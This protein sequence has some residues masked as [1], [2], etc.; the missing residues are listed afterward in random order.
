MKAAVAAGVSS[1]A[2]AHLTVSEV[3]AEASDQTTIFL[4]TEGKRKKRVPSD[5]YNHLQRAFKVNEKMKNRF[6]G[7]EGIAA[8]GVSAGRFGGDNPYVTVD[9]DRSSKKK[10][11]RRGEVPESHQDVRIETA[12][13]AE[14]AEPLCD[15]DIIQINQT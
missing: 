8:V 3:K 11:E 12:E 6:M 15:R 7:K 10:V 1:T 2:A 14:A 9:L 5:W 13:A 4:D